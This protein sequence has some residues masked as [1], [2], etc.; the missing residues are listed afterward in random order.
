MHG[1]KWASCP[2]VFVVVLKGTASEFAEKLDEA[3]AL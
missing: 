3:A 1:M 2:S